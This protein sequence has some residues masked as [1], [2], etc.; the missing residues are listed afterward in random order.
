VSVSKRM[1]LRHSTK[2]ALGFALITGGAYAAYQVISTKLAL[3]ENFS[4]LT[5]GDVNVVGIDAGAGYRI[6]VA[7]QMAQLV[8]ASDNFS[9]NDT[10]DGGATEGAIKRRV[11]VREMLNT[12]KGDSKALGAFVMSLNDM[13]ENDN[14][15]P[16]RVFW[17]AE[18]IQ[19]ALDGDKAMV[20]SLEHDLNMHLDGT[21][22]K[23]LR[24]ASMQNGIIVDSPVTVKVNLHGKVTPVVGRVFEPYRPRLMRAVEDRYK[25]KPDVTEEMQ[26]GYYAEEARKVISGETPKESVRDSLASRIS[27]ELS[28]E[29]AAAPTRVLKSATIVLNDALVRHA[30]YHAYDTT[31][32]KMFDLSVE[33]SDEGRRRLWKY[34][35]ERVGTQLLLVADGIPIAAPR[36]QHELAQDSLTITQ[37]EDEVLVRDAVEML[38]QKRDLAKK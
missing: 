30:S 18:D 17:Q 10:N 4:I 23:T 12:L 7:N 13:K 38:N 5:P 27:K 36:I 31:R 15:P 3:Q 11:P 9:S 25:D 20:A 24:I 1:V 34:S 14:W 37:M 26:I 35:K 33:V 6:I 2:I 16:E 19:K 29:R 22:L 32:G 8:Q 21:P 28:E